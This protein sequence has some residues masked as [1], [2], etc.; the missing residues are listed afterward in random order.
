M[1]KYDENWY[2]LQADRDAKV[3]GKQEIVRGT[4]NPAGACQLLHE[5]WK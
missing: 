2:R 4:K 1:V 5:K 3:K